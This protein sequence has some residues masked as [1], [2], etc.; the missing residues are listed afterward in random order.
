LGTNA[1]A[2]S[3]FDVLD[4]FAYGDGMPDHFMAHAAGIEGWS[5]R[6]MSTIIT[7]AKSSTRR[8]SVPIHCAKYGYPIRKPHNA[9]P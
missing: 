3:D 2:I 5:L 6:N 7:A 9:R 1:D 8:K 4:I